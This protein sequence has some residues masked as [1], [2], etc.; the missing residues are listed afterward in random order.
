VCPETTWTPWPPLGAAGTFS[1]A[2]RPLCHIVLLAALPLLAAGCNLAKTSTCTAV[3]SCAS[4]GFQ[5]G[6]FVDACG[7]AHD[8]GG[9]AAGRSCSR[10]DGTAGFCALSGPLPRAGNPDGHCL[11]TLPPEA[12]PVDTSRPTTVVGDGTA[13]SCT[14][15]AL[16]TAIA[17]GG[18]ITFA[19][20]ADP[21][22]IPVTA[23]LRLPT[24]RDTVIDGGGMVTLDGGSAV[25]ILSWNDGN[26]LT[27]DH[28]LTL[29]HL[30]LQ[31]G[32]ATGTSLLASA[33]P[34]C[35]QGYLDGQGGALFMRNGILH[36]V[37]VTFAGNQAALLGPDTGG[38][39]IYLLG[40]K[41]A[42]I[43]SCSFLANRASNAGALGALFATLSIYDSLFDGNDATG[44]GANSDD[45]N[46]CPVLNVNGQYQVG[47][48]GNGGAL[49]SD[50]VAMS[51]TV[52]GT[53]VRSNHAGAFGSAIFFT[54]NDPSR[55]GTLTIRDS[56]MFG[57]VQ[58]SNWWQWKPGISTNAATVEPVNSDI[59]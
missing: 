48:G 44:T 36:A 32:K 9:C 35:S 29:Q 58:D 10:A 17:A 18:V 43:S 31:N 22:T 30:V 47:S 25:R 1:A 14:H 4:Q 33:P 45:R 55:R 50:G 12:L 28:V 34:P 5:C 39:A 46:Q 42:T 38:G 54:S 52:C 59:R 15:A 3:Q 56:L 13:A 24:D 41:P 2:V 57:N 27:S 20:G 51:I 49:C 11:A 7:N 53:Q 8:C 21:V 37:D 26:W 40:A 23:T 19:C 6:A 16:A